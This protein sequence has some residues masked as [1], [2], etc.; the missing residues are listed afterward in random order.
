M[1][2]LRDLRILS[3]MPVEVGT[4]GD[5]RGAAPARPALERQAA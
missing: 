2:G 4:P 3:L 5:F 1:A